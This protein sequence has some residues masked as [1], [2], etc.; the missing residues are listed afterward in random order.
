VIFATGFGV[1]TLPDRFWD[2][3]KLPRLFN[4]DTFKKAVQKAFDER[5]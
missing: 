1:K 4:L 2:T 3:P 5:H